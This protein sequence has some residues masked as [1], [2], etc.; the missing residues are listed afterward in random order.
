MNARIIIRELSRGDIPG[1]GMAPQLMLWGERFGA[2]RR[3][4]PNNIQH[5]LRPFSVTGV[6]IPSD[7]AYFGSA[8][9][10]ARR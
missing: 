2:G 1:P 3:E 7:F 6:G 8:Q 4:D 9:G 5:A 10:V